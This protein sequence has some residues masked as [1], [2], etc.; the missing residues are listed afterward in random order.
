MGIARN[1]SSRTKIGTKITLLAVCPVFVALAAV[2]VTIAVQRGRLAQ[3]T[4]NTVRQ[5]A[6]SEA[7]KIAQ[8]TYLLC[9]STEARNQKDLTRSLGVAHD[10]VVQA[11]GVHLAAETVV[12]WQAVNQF[13]KQPSMLTLPKM[14][15]GF[16]WPGQDASAT[17]PALVADD[18]RRLT[19]SFCTIFQRMNDAGDMLRICTS[20]LK[21]DG[22][23]AL[24]TFIPAKNSDGTNNL[25]V[26]TVLGGKTYHGRAF[27][28][29]EWHAAAYEPIWDDAHARIIG[30]LY[31]GVPLATI[32]QEIHDAIVKMKVGKTGY[33]FVVGT[34]GDQRGRYIISAQGKRDGESI[35]EAK[36]ASGNLF[37]QSIVAKA[38]AVR[39]G[40]ADCEVYPW[41]NAGDATARMKLTAVTYYAAWDWVIG[42]GAY[43]DD[44]SEVRS[45]LVDSQNV[46]MRWIVI[47]AVVGA[48]VTTVVGILFSRRISAPLVR[49][50]TDL[51]SGS[52]Q[53]TAAAAQVSG[54][55]QSLAD[56]ASAQAASLEES[57]ASLEEL[58]SMTK[59]NADSAQ[60]A[61]QVASQARTSADTGVERMRAMQTAMQAITHSSAD[62]SKILKTI[63]EI[64][65]QTNLLALNAA[66]EAARAGEAGAGFAIVADEVRSLAQRSALAAKETAAKID[67]SV[68]KSRQGAQISSE[69]AMSFETI[70][71]QILQL[72]TLV[73][74]IAV[75]SNEQSQGIGQVTTAVS[76]MDRVTQS[77][78][79]SAEET[80]AASQDLKAQASVLSEAAQS[81]QE[82]VGTKAE[83]TVSH[84]DEPVQSD[85]EHTAMPE[86]HTMATHDQALVRHFG[87]KGERGGG[88]VKK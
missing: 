73:G 45:Q 39:E 21:T 61:K 25:V 4:D 65:F 88:N 50:I 11:G 10:L 77:N 71:Q 30:M 22:T 76:E 6:F 57:S 33:V 86:H 79:A 51:R 40:E 48:F 58:A 28:V 63:D 46:L 17:A 53:I 67:D 1:I 29:N 44:F 62:I 69:V 66:V 8:N 31:V 3:S 38:L 35:W 7:A 36:D 49:V 64:S 37:I 80:S 52:D 75:A 59:R 19:G 15:V 13:T 87:E 70:Q 85:Q 60:Q 43:T 78:A 32:N 20:V 81:M 56:G 47:V 72:D 55:S 41:K 84:F 5:Q 24:G 23:R 54:A 16:G 14:L 83:N 9:D 68:A 74:E 82:L 42:A 27:V 26:Q 12:T 2:F 18:V 34:K